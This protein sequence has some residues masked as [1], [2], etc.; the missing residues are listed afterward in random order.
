MQGPTWSNLEAMCYSNVTGFAGGD[1]VIDTSSG[2]LASFI[3]LAH[4]CLFTG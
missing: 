1:Y 3:A 2:S 4:D